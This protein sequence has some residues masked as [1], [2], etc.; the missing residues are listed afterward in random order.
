MNI[1]CNATNKEEI[2]ELATVVK[3][4]V[5]TERIKQIVVTC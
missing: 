1:S 2:D 3:V 4:F 5:V